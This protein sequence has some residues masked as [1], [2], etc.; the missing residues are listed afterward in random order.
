MSTNEPQVNTVV[1]SSSTQTPVVLEDNKKYTILLN[2]IQ[3]FV[4]PINQLLK[5]EKQLKNVASLNDLTQALAKENLRLKDK[6]IELNPIANE[7]N[8]TSI[9]FNDEIDKDNY[10]GF[11][12]ITVKTKPLEN[13]IIPVLTPQML[14]QTN[15]GYVIE[16]SSDDF[17]GMAQVE[18]QDVALASNIEYIVTPADLV[19]YN[20]EDEVYKVDFKFTGTGAF[21]KF[22]NE[23]KELYTD[24]KGNST[25][26]G[27][28]NLTVNVPMVDYHEFTVD[29]K[30]LGKTF[31]PADIPASFDG[32]GG[33]AGKVGIKQFKV[34][35]TLKSTLS[36]TTLVDCAKK[37][38]GQEFTGGN[39]N[40]ESSDGTQG[41]GLGYP[42][43]EVPPITTAYP[44]S[45][46]LKGGNYPLNSY[47]YHLEDDSRNF[48]CYVDNMDMI[49]GIKY[50]VLPC[51]YLI[52]HID[53]STMQ[54]S[55]NLI[56]IYKNKLNV[57]FDRSECDYHTYNYEWETSNTVLNTYKNS[58]DS[59]T[60]ILID[61]L[62]LPFPKT[63]DLEF[64]YF[65]FLDDIDNSSN[66]TNAALS[67]YLAPLIPTSTNA[68]A[69]LKN[70]RV[71]LPK[72]HSC[73]QDGLYIAPD[74]ETIFNINSVFPRGQIT[75]SGLGFEYTSQ[76]SQYSNPFENYT[77]KFPKLD[78]TYY[79]YLCV[80]GDISTNTNILTFGTQLSIPPAFS[81]VTKQ[82]YVAAAIVSSYNADNPLQNAIAHLAFNNTEDINN[83]KVFYGKMST[84]NSITWTQLSATIQDNIPAFIITDST[85][86]TISIILHSY[87]ANEHSSYNYSNFYYITTNENSLPKNIG[88]KEV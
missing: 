8:S 74:K 36:A 46:P 59:N 30:T 26:F 43:I 58:T 60:P 23:I 49:Y 84:T 27:A 3:R 45:T 4:K 80:T 16:K 65:Y 11:N 56:N 67:S 2:D 77:I 40:A 79:Y 57:N 28:K 37:G 62:E 38:G 85:S 64:S 66:V 9:D 17:C 12:S 15:T 5:P 54:I 82:N 52:D 88:E 1:E 18:I 25:V 31:I 69:L 19:N 78:A 13:K 22:S 24:S 71:V 86:K 7:I 20:N 75:Y 68:G 29:A 32:T 14:T 73:L 87:F 35:A 42:A 41:L 33:A 51:G 81:N 63:A 83:I 47:H 53:D 6:V 50:A 61:T 44:Y 48:D 34:K 39:C 76:S 55:D 21:N 70:I 10:L 72:V